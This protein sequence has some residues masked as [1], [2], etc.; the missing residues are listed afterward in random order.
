MCEYRVDQRVMVLNLYSL[1]IIKIL[2]T[3]FTTVKVS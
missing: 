3:E 2:V 1:S